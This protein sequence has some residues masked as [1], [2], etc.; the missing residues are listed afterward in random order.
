VED[1][2]LH[3]VGE[4]DACD[5][6]LCAF[7]AHG[8]DE[9]AH[10]RLFLRKDMLDPCT[11]FGF[12]PIGGA[13]RFRRAIGGVVLRHHFAQLRPIMAGAVRD[14]RFADEAKAGDRDID[15]RFAIRGN[16]RSFGEAQDRLSELDS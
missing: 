11:D 9:Q 7:D 14:H 13:Q 10:M 6:G 3:I 8:A 1:R 15:L 16:A 5:L 2:A 12:D 4:D